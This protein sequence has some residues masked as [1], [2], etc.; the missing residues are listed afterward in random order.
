MFNLNFFYLQTTLTSASQYLFS[1]L[2]GRAFLRSATVI[3]PS[4][5]PESCVNVPITSATDETS[6]VTIVPSETARGRLWTQQSLG[7]GQPGDQIYL[8]HESLQSRDDAL[9]TSYPY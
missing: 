8:G 3:L 6:D 7:C 9:G 1:A 2:D 5:W 4:S